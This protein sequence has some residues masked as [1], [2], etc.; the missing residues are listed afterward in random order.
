MDAFV[1][2]D[3]EQYIKL[4]GITPPDKI[5]YFPENQYQLTEEDQ[6][7]VKNVYNVLQPFI[8]KNGIKQKRSFI[9]LLRSA[10]T[11]PKIIADPQKHAIIKDLLWRMFVI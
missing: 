5:A 3:R 10:V 8:I 7:K 2:L 1:V 9:S 4:T 6:Q 11:S